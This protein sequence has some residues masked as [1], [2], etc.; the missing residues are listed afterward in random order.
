MSPHVDTDIG[1]DP[2]YAMTSWLA[3][4]I[5]RSH[6]EL[7]RRGAV[8][9]F[10]KPSLEAGA[11]GF[12]IVD[13]RGCRD[14]AGLQAAVLDAVAHFRRTSSRAAKPGRHALIVAFVNMPEQQWSLIDDVHRRVKDAVVVQGLMIGQFHPRCPAPAVHNSQ[15]LVNR[16]PIPLFAIRHMAL[17]DILFLR[18]EPAWFPA[19]RNRFGPRYRRCAV[20]EAHL[21]EAFHD[22]QHRYLASKQAHGDDVAV[23]SVDA[24]MLARDT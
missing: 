13:W 18:D 4:Y 24:A 14:S 17:H 23:T 6:P 16:S 11:I 3:G 15:F 12:Q 10:V 7:G 19:Y 1:T 9:P 5:S 21:V 2:F 22:A 8:C 20:A